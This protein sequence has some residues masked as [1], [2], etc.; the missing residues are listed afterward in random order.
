MS[1]SIEWLQN[2]ENGSSF[3]WFSH[4]E[5][6][7]ASTMEPFYYEL[8]PLSDTKAR[9]TITNDRWQPISKADEPL[10]K[11]MGKLM[12]E[13]FS[14]SILYQNKQ[15]HAAISVPTIRTNP[16][17]G[18][19]KLIAFDIE[20]VQ[21]KVGNDPKDGQNTKS[22]SV[23]SSGRWAKVNI[24]RSGIYRITYNELESW[25]LADKNISVWG[26]GGKALPYMNSE[27][28][29]DDL[30]QVPIFIEKGSDGI[31]NTGDYILFYGEGPETYCYKENYD[32][33]TTEQH[34]YSQTISYFI[35]AEQ[36]Q[37]LI[38]SCS[39]PDDE[40][41]HTSQSYDAVAVFEN[42]DT[43]LVMSGRQWFGDIFDINTTRKYSSQLNSPV[44]GSTMKVMVQ[45]A[46]KSL[47]STYFT[48]K[49]NS[50][51]IG[52][53]RMGSISGSSYS[54]VVSVNS[55]L[56]ATPIPEG[57]I[58]IELTY[59]KTSAADVAWLD[60]IVIN[61]RQELRYNGDQLIFW[62]SQTVGHDNITRYTLQ[63]T[64]TSTQVWDITNLNNTQKV[65]TTGSNSLVFEQESDTLHKYI[66]FTPEKAYSVEFA[67]AVENQNIHGIGQ[68]NMV[69][70]THPDYITQ[71]NEIAQIHR[72]LD[73]LS[74]E[75]FTTEQVYN[76]F[77]SGNDDVSAIR[78][79]MRML[80]QRAEDE[81]DEPRY[82][83]LFGDGS[84]NNL[85]T[86]INNTN[87]IPTFQS[88]NS[89]NAT[90][91]YVTDDFFGLL[92]KDEGAGTGLLDI[93]VGRLPAS[94][95]DQANSLL[96][97]IKTYTSKKN[98]ADWQNMLCF[99][100]DDEDNNTHMDDA[101]KLAD[102]VRGKH[103]EYNVQKIF[104]DAYPQ[105][106]LSTGHSYPDV[107]EAINARMN[108][109][110]LLFNYTGHANERW[111]SHEKV[112]M[113]NDILAWQ[114]INVLPLFI[115]A[116][117]EF[118]RF[119]NP[120]LISAGEHV[121]LSPNGGAVALLSTTRVVYSSPNYTLNYN[122]ISRVFE[123]DPQTG[124]FYALGD[125]VKQSKNN[126]GSGINKL[127]FSLLGD[128]A[129]KL[130]YPT[131][132]ME[133]LTINGVEIDELSDTLKSLDRVILTGRI[134]DSEEHTVTSFN[135]TTTI[136]LYDKA[137]EITTLAND[138][139]SP[140]T[141][142]S[143]ENV[144]FKGNAA[145]TNGAFSIEFL[146][147]KDINFAYG[148]G[149]ISMFATDEQTSAMGSFSDIIIGGINDNAEVDNEGPEIQIYL[150]DEDF[151]NG[152]ICNTNPKLLVKLN[153]E[154]GINTTGIGIGHDFIAILTNPSGSTTEI[155]LNNYYTSTNNDFRQGEANYQFSNLNI[156][157]HTL[158]IK[159]WDV[160]NNSS[161]SKITFIVTSG[162]EL[163]TKNLYCYP[164][165][166][167]SS[168]TSFYF[169]HNQPDTQMD[170][171]LKIY[172][173]A[174]T[175]VKQIELTNNSGNYRYGPIYWDGN[176]QQ[177]S[178]LSRGVYFCRLNV[179]T[180]NGQKSVLQQ[181]IVVAR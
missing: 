22:N 161:E 20:I 15:P 99:V 9:V 71:A 168:G 38:S 67:G 66:A 104:F 179:S 171:S 13:Q 65:T 177:G 84:Y 45:A 8:I 141:F 98:I 24:T 32:I 158:A 118:S 33:W 47:Y 56:I 138:G 37:K 147:P 157:K 69:I 78:N 75:V 136:A 105:S 103:P 55:S 90:S 77:S 108:N 54:N 36:P 43:N 148:K 91:S 60:Y 139:G 96:N 40:F 102:H 156:G 29:P 14:Y 132:K 58:N 53:L 125:L 176:G 72:T 144:L 48:I 42:N 1:R 18:Y 57:T 3:L 41:T 127:N 106:V 180:S 76:E 61:A 16:S 129:L 92:D 94:T 97:K 27:A 150:N 4:A 44:A 120:N 135:G 122:F 140:M 133:L 145:V 115:T 25:G 70:V 159:A 110:T 21:G 113:T 74:V 12:G 178:T 80:Y 169:E 82:L 175:L 51:Q 26:N 130:R 149:K 34:P 143:Q 152:G 39:E 62:D 73:N 49:A 87:R 170:I 59:N 109:G 137:V 50:T 163:I 155:N 85:S 63:N 181:K 95:T 131:Y 126:S 114:N 164:N 174:G 116:T 2:K 28:C 79:L 52:T 107:T 119:D 166:I 162:D 10:I 5:Y 89:I 153:D 111:I 81:D 31:F 23:L 93:G 68:P 124:N 6:P 167:T 83:L 11:K 121:I 64:T 117:C 142:M 88:E 46:A 134:F 151:T 7:N 154:S 112:I 17:I 146:I 123:K 128:P 19:E 165:P 100:G 172:S 30:S 173:V 101:N 160:H 86:S 35:T